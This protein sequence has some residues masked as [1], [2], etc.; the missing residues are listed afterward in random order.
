MLADWNGPRTAFDSEIMP[1]TTPPRGSA[2]SSRHPSGA[3]RRSR[4]AAS[5]RRLR[6]ERFGPHGLERR[7][8]VALG[9]VQRAQHPRVARHPPPDRARHG[10]TTTASPPPRGS[11]AAAN[12]PARSVATWRTAEVDVA[13]RPGDDALAQPL[14]SASVSA[15]KPCSQSSPAGSRGS[16]AGR[17]RRAARGRARSGRSA[18]GAWPTGSGPSRSTRPRAPNHPAFGDGRRHHRREAL[19]RPRRPVSGQVRPACC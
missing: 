2:T 8:E 3:A 10:C 18:R 12:R 9:R 5:L 16:E 15:G 4:S 11:P 13:I 17:P 7:E 19:T 1:A 14:S 6:E